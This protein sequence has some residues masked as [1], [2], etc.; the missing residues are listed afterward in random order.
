MCVCE[1]LLVQ[2]SIPMS[3]AQIFTQQSAE[4]LKINLSLSDRDSDQAGAGGKRA[5]EDRGRREEG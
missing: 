2:F 1:G 5:E 4:P 3:R